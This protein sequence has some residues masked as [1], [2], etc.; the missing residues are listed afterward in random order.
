[1][2][3]FYGALKRRVH[4]FAEGFAEIFGQYVTSLTLIFEKPSGLQ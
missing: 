1:M 3:D 4:A 2:T